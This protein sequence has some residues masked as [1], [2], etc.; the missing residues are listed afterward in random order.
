MAC[1]WVAELEI[2]HEPFDVSAPNKYKP[3]GKNGRHK[4]M[5][6]KER[7]QSDR[8]QLEDELEAA[9]QSQSPGARHA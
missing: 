5:Y 6:P 9:K 3:S 8:K 1:D 2:D 4:R 7:Y